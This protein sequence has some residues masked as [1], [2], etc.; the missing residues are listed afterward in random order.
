MLL[1]TFFGLCKCII[2]KIA[3]ASTAPTL[4][5][6][7]ICSWEPS[8]L[9]EVSWER[10]NFRYQMQI[11]ISDV[12]PI[13]FQFNLRYLNSD[14]RECFNN[15]EHFSD[16]NWFDSLLIPEKIK[17]TLRKPKKSF[18]DYGVPKKRHHCRCTLWNAKIN[19]HF[20]IRKRTG[21][22]APCL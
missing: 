19:F 20:R 1:L 22:A 6:A 12:E 15:L 9:V 2:G 16:L 10:Y 17:C 21:P 3:E 14:G 18:K 5:G 4:T 7:L 8:K 13:R 11:L